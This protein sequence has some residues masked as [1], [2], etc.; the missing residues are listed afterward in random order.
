MKRAFTLLELLIAMT[1]LVIILTSTYTLFRSA[2]GAYSKGEIRSE[3]YQQVRVIFGIIEREIASAASV[4]GRDNYF[5]GNQDRVFFVA[6]LAEEEEQD[7]REVGYW[8]SES[9]QSL[10][11][12]EDVNPDFDFTTA[13]QTDELGVHITRLV[14]AYY[15]GTN[16]R[17]SWDSQTEQQLP[18]AVK[19]EIGIQDSRGKQSSDFSTT[20]RIESTQ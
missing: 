20:V 7:L 18:R 12:Q 8:L 14:V 10:M 6:P 3:L 5:S 4:P 13:D 15:D 1:I 16:W 9:D 11:R 19:V 2:S 17:N